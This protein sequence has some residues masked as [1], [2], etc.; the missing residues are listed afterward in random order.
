MARI[1]I[2]DD[3]ELIRSSYARCFAD[4]GHEILV[5]ASLAEGG[6]HA[7]AGVDVIYLDLDLPDGDGKKAIDALASAPGRPE[8][9]VVT[10]LGSNYGA[11]EALDG[12]AWDYI[13]KPASPMTLRASL[14]DA[15]HYRRDRY[16]HGAAP[17]G[18][19]AF[20]AC[21][22]IGESPAIKRTLRCIAQA[23]ESEAN[24]LV[25]GETGVGKEMAARAIHANS[26][27]RDMPFVVVDC[28]NLSETLVESA[29]YGHLKGAFTGAHADR[30]GLVAEADGGTLFLD[31]IG[32]LPPALQKSFLRV[33]Q[34][35]C[36]RAV[37]SSRQQ[38][39]DFRLV[40][41]T[42]R[43]LDAMTDTGEFRSDLL[44]RVR[45]VEVQLPP[46]RDR[47]EDLERLA[48]H[49]GV[50]ACRRAGLAA[51]RISRQT[52]AV[53]AGHDWPGN[54][55]ELASVIEAAVI[56]A[57]SGPG[58][59]PKH[60][61][62]QVRMAGLGPAAPAEEAAPASTLSAGTAGPAPAP[63]ASAMQT[64]DEYRSACDKVYFEELM[65][66]CGQNVVEASRTAGI[67]VPSIYRRLSQA[68]IPTPGRRK[69]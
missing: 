33:L 1:L 2:I 68:G 34:E 44:F 32:E 40:A 4:L 3:D 49:F 17:A 41:A 16:A 45:T 35:H 42:N 29:L 38:R 31:E 66:A 22:I 12:G 46:L 67:S 47:V 18:G 43:D 20:D 52:M 48:A 19:P 25:L 62:G 28:S 58:I 53:L 11:R 21:G 51:K 24:V 50:L 54:V 39:S 15:L 37:G 23:A 36:F 14:E 10:G 5:A 63:N 8:I 13:Q 69:R 55:R 56:Q 26:P 60:L 65:E 9:V 27:R 59:Y 30:R 64:Y 61:P 6:E 7:A 57:G